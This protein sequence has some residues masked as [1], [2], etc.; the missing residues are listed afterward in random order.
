M[1]I[2]FWVKDSTKMNIFCAYSDF[3]IYE[4]MIQSELCA[5]HHA[6]D[7]VIDPIHV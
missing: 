2:A 7:V 6:D 4:Q 3:S 5:D 1:E